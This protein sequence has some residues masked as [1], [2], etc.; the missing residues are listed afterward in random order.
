MF[1]GKI[2]LNFQKWVPS[3]G[4]AYYKP[5]Q[6]QPPERVHKLKVGKVLTLGTRLPFPLFALKGLS[7]KDLCQACVFKIK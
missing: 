3:E 1:L 7:Q 6:N 4:F 2:L 5:L